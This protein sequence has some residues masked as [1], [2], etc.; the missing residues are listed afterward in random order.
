MSANDDCPLPVTW[1]ADS[2]FYYP[3]P[4]D[5]ALADGICLGRYD[6]TG[7]EVGTDEPDLPVLAWEPS[8]FYVEE[9]D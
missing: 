9:K 8:L 3:D 2:F 5:R 6:E 4:S 1:D 7:G